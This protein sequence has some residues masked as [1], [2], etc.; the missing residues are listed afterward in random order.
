MHKD[1]IVFLDWLRVA[2]CLMVM[3]VHSIEPFYLGEGGTLILN[4]ANGVWSTVLDSALRAAV[5]L[6]ILTSSYLLF[7]VKS[8]T[9]T[10]LRRRL[11]RVGW[12]LLVWVMLYALIPQYGTQW[13]DYDFI[14]N[15]KHALLNFPDAAGHLWFMFML[16]GVYL[17]MPIFSPWIEKVSK[18]GEQ[19]FL[20]LWL[21]TTTIVFWRELAMHVFGQHRVWGEAFWNEFGSFYYVSGFMGYVVLGHYLKK[22]V[23]DMNWKRTLSIAL[24]LWIVGYCITAGWFWAAMPKSFPVRD[25]ILLAVYMEDSWCFC[26]IGVVLTTIAYFLVARKFVANGRFYRHLIVPLSR[27]SFGMYLIHIFVLT[28]VFSVLSQRLSDLNTWVGTPLI[29]ALTATITFVI[30]ALLSKLISYLP[31][32]RYIIGE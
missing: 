17:A 5:P 20:L 10:F 15:F 18:R 25:D 26:T 6:F 7:P 1:R 4:E 8:S 3:G 13:N 23:P 12:P 28:A 22:Y 29:I 14:G 31:F 19:A 27:L 2:A 32:S 16:I 11:S 30:S 9:E 21:F 24:P